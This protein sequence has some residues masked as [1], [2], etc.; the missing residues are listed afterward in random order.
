IRDSPGIRVETILSR[1]AFLSTFRLWIDH[2][3][4]IALDTTG[5]LSPPPPH[6]LDSAENIR[7][8]K[9]HNVVITKS[10]THGE[11]WVDGVLRS[12]NDITIPIVIPDHNIHMLVGQLQGRVDDLEIYRQRLGGDDIR[13]IAHNTSLFSD[14][15]DGSESN[16]IELNNFPLLSYP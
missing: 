8:D 15:A 11:L 13:A 10:G 6:L 5:F 12:S 3:G 16:Q 7:D 2:N 14:G 1:E 9:W 4:H